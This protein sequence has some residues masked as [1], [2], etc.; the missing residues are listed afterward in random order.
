MD[1][2]RA[3]PDALKRRLFSSTGVVLITRGAAALLTLT[4][5]LKVSDIWDWV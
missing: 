5:S 3:I 1:L 2:A 4:M